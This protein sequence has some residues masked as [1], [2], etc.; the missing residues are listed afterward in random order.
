VYEQFL[1]KVIRLTPSHRAKVEEKPE[2]KKAGG[3]YYTPAYI[4]DYIVKQTV[5]KL[6]EGKTPRQIS[7][8]HILDPACGSGS[9][10]LGA[11]QYLLDYHRQWYEAHDPAKHARAKQPALYQGPRGE[12]RL[13]TAE[14]KRIL[15]NNIYGVD[16]DRQAVEVTKL[17]LLLKVLE[18]ESDETLGQQL[19]L[20]RERALPNLGD[21][22]KCG[23][24]LIGPDYC[25]GR[26]LALFNDEVMRRI[27]IFDWQAD[28][29]EIMAAG[30]FDCVIGNPPWL[31]AGYYVTDELDYLR[32]TFKSAKGKFDLYYLFIEQGCWLLSDKGLFGMIVP[33][34]LFHTKA[35]SNLRELLSELKW[36][37]GIVDFGHEQIFSGA[38]NYS[39]ILLLQKQPGPNPKYIRA[40]AGLKVVQEFDVP[41]SLFS[42][43]MW[44]FEDEAT[45]NLFEKLEAIGQPLEQIAVRFGTGVQSGADRLLVLD[46][47]AAKTQGLETALLRTV[48]K[49][50]D[51]RR[52]AVS[53]DSKLLVFPYR[54]E[55][56]EFAILTETELQQYENVFS[57]LTENKAK[58]ARRVW[59]GRSAE[60]LSGKWYGMMYLDSCAYFA[61]PHILTPSLSNRSNFA[62]GTGDLFVTGTA[63]V[64]SIIPRDDLKESIQYSLGVLN[65]SLLSFYAVGHSPVF[66]GGY[67][68]FSAPDLKKLP[69]RRINFDDPEDVA[70]HDK[71]VALVEQMLDLH[72]KL[73]AASI[74][75]DRTLYQRQIDATDREI[76]GLVYELYGLTKEEIEIIEEATQ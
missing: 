70:R 42:S 53:D 58:L 51:V 7:K 23:N 45:R 60:E 59:F 56:G 54:V 48:L 14:K 10:L 15:L 43:D 62:L 28:F 4:V 67:F 47:R 76:D 57:Q 63:G 38:T 3:V 25:E 18:G 30:G 74:P 19:T 64:T 40:R 31:M 69:I 32:K 6:V 8:V 22:I 61:V 9:F 65:S 13:T 39:C 2:V 21:N 75:A 49:G 26:Q 41:W 24:S 50:R 52:Y 29:P 37:R 1:G 72:K 5:G 12:W 46:R 66:S 71:M 17:S 35:A 73:A 20:W 55:R 34:K 36:I 16:I 44:H 11:Y 68:K 33:N 27:N